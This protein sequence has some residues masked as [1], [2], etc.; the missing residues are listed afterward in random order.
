MKRVACGIVG[1]YLVAA[2]LMYSLQ[3]GHKGPWHERYPVICHALGRTREGESLTNSKE[4]FLYNYERGQRVFEADIQ[5]TSDNIMVLRHD[6]TSGLGQEEAFGWTDEEQWPVTAQEFLDAPIYGM[7]TPLTLEDWFAIMQRYPDI[8]L[9]TDTKYSP[10][11]G[12]QFRLLADTALENGYEDVL[13]RVIVQ[14]Y[15][16]EMYDEVMAVYP[17]KNLIWTL[18]YI[19]YPGKEEII[20]FMAEKELP[21]LVMPSAWWNSQYQE[22]LENSGIKVYVHTVDEAEEARQRLEQ[23]VSGIYTDDILPVDVE[24]WLQK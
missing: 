11:V 15:Y 5:I 16:K 24:R 7:Y 2:V 14:I 8:W 1:A 22:E 13:K 17:F 4:A 18:Y 20:D 21:V 19:G 23:G 9:V 3:T 12:P 6:W 10:D